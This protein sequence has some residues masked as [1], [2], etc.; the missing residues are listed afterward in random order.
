[1][2]IP[3]K[4]LRDIA[5]ITSDGLYDVPTLERLRTAL[6]DIDREVQRRACTT[7]HGVG[8]YPDKKQRVD[9]VARS[10]SLGEILEFPEAIDPVVKA[11]FEKPSEYTKEGDSYLQNMV[12]RS[13]LTLEMANLIF[14]ASSYESAMKGFQFWDRVYSVEKSDAAV[15]ELCR[16][17]SPITTNILHLVKHKKTR[18]IHM[19]DDDGR[20]WEDDVYFGSQRK[21]AESELERRGNPPY[22]PE[23]YL[24]H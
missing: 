5:A 22:E 24:K 8:W 19:S 11:L 13:S 9:I 2:E 14:I 20:S 7:L 1:M 10:W 15:L 23:A 17:V 6:N 16:L 12:P 18:T 3:D 4:N 21:R